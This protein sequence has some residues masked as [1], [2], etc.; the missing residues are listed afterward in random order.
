MIAGITENKKQELVCCLSDEAAQLVYGRYGHIAYTAL[1]EEQL[2]AAIKEMVVRTRN[3]LVT[4]H[5]LRKMVQSHDQPVQTFLSNLKATARMCEYKVKCEDEMCGKMVDFTE[6]MV[7]EQLT[8]GLADEEA[9]RKLFTKPN[10][11]LAEAEKLVVAEEI[12][13]LSQED[14]RSVAGVS[15]YKRDKKDAHTPG[16]RCKWCGE[17][18][19]GN[20]TELAVRKENCGAWNERCNKCSRL[21]HFPKQC[22]LIKTRKPQPEK[23]PKQT[24]SEI[25]EV[26]LEINALDTENVDHLNTIPSGKV[27][28][29]SSRR[30]ILRHM[31][32]DAQSGKYVNCWSRRKMKSLAVEVQLDEDGYRELSDKQAPGLE[33]TQGGMRGTA[34]CSSV[35]DTGASVVCSGT[36][37]LK[38]SYN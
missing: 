28:T 33:H 25:S 15:Q 11:T 29:E 10:V 13:K 12:G 7:L 38:S 14:S 34:K 4:R 9:Q 2:L 3:K 23:N 17:A 19:H 20:D 26:L 1:T 35:A 31:R 22:H 16:K 36:D 37:I 21:G 24:A 30:R 8:V 32:F 27:K 5:K 18:S 6:Q